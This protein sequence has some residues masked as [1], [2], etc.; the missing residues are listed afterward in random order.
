MEIKIDA[1][2]DAS[3]EYVSGF[4]LLPILRRRTA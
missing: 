2:T 3:T 1:V 4:A